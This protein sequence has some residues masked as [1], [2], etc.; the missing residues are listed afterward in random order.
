MVADG[1]PT[2][3]TEAQR[4][5]MS[6]DLG[7]S[8]FE[9]AT[10]QG[11]V[12]AAQPHVFWPLSSNDGLSPSRVSPLRAKRLHSSFVFSTV[13]A[14][15]KLAMPLRALPSTVQPEICA[16]AGSLRSA[17]PLVT[18]MPSPKLEL[19]ALFLV[20]RTAVLVSD[21]SPPR[22]WMPACSACSTTEE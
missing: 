16:L 15:P 1:Q 10:L 4:I 9:L 14:A 21:R 2:A 13:T 22:T 8:R 5:S 11:S 6:N 20:R 7:G 12:V 17:P 19:L 3:R 18:T